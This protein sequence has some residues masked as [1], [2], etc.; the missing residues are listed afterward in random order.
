MNQTI[1][2]RVAKLR[3]A[4]ERAG[5]DYYMVPTA[6]FH[7]SEYVDTYFKVRE[8]L[9]GFTG[10]N[11]TLVVSRDEAGLW[12]DGRYF[13]QAENE[14]EGTGITLFRMLDEGVPTIKEYLKDHMKEGQTLGFD[15]RVVDT[16]FGCSLEKIL[17]EENRRILYQAIRRLEVKKREVIQ[18]QYFG[19]MSQ[20]EIAAVLHITPENV[21]VLAYRAKKELKKDLEELKK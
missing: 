21:R 7:N 14:L 11:G 4:M 12:T 15:G 13:I 17:E 2:N 6:D 18:M 10:S 20:K 9:S 19:G 16:A 8:Y 1:R 5:V 3:E